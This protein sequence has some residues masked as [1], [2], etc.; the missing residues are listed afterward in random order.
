MDE[1]ISDEELER[2]LIERRRRRAKSIDYSKV[3]KILTTRNSNM[4][5]M[6]MGKGREIY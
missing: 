1:N 5:D 3:G 2:M 4:T 6:L